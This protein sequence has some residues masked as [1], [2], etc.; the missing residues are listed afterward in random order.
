MTSGRIAEA[1]SGSGSA[2]DR[3][4]ATVKSALR[5]LLVIE[6][7]T[8]EPIG[9]SFAQIC[10][11]LGLPKSSTHALL[12]T[13]KERGHLDLDQTGRYRLGIRIWQAGQAHTQG[14]DLAAAARPYLQVARDE[15]HETVQ[16]AVLDG[17]E[18]VYL[19][20]EDSDQRLVLQSRVGSRLPAY[21]TGLGKGPLVRFERRRGTC[22]AVQNRFTRLHD[23]DDKRPCC[24][25][26]RAPK[27]TPTRLRDRPWRVHRRGDLRR[28]PGA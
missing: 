19:A 27:G 25:A 13:M 12:R 4:S 20:K 22:Q 26:R 1:A 2:G 7:L 16:L 5:V 21:A 10:K 24:A 18:N 3:L 11:R 9:L 8:D 17:F 28:R 14:F 15:L 23:Q 6:L